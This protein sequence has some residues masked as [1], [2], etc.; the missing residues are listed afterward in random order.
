MEIILF[1]S[2]I[3]HYHN[4]NNNDNADNDDNNNNNNNNNNNSNN[5]QQLLNEAEQD[6]KNSADQGGCYPQT[7]EARG[8]Y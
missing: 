2:T 8:G 6:V 7:A 1:L 4:N 5:N 3:N